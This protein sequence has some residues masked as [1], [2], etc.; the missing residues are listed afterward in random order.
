MIMRLSYQRD[1]G[2][3]YIFPQGKAMIVG[4]LLPNTG[5]APAPRIEFEYVDDPEEKE[6]DDTHE[7]V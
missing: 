6:V 4:S 3:V 2:R 5:N 7:Y 1:G